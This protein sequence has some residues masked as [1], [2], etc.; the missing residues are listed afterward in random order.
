[1]NKKVVV[2][3]I[4]LT[5]LLLI[6]SFILLFMKAP[7][8]GTKATIYMNNEVYKTIDLTEKIYMEY[9]V[10]TEYGWNKIIVDNG[11][12]CVSDSDC[13]DKTCVKTG[14]I[15]GSGMPIICMPHR[16]EIII[17]ADNYD[18]LTG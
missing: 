3:L 17:S 15:N 1:M 6:C 7:E 13:P 12:I 16:L 8:N 5:G 9:T 18:G 2:V 14:F 11:K 10:E 4:V